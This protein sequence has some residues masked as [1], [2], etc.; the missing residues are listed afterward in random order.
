MTTLLD[1]YS[2][3][4]GL[5]IVTSEAGRCPICRRMTYFFINRHG[6]SAC[7]DCAALRAA[8]ATSHRPDGAP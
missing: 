7:L 2:T 3:R 5:A 8:T 4:D 1:I 6:H